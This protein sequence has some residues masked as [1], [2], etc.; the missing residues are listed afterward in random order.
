MFKKGDV[1]IYRDSSDVGIV[2]GPV[3]DLPERLWVNWMSGEDAG[4]RRHCNIEDLSP[5]HIN[6]N[7]NKG[8]EEYSVKELKKFLD[9]MDDNIV[10]SFSDLKIK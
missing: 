4:R 5:H 2:D 10:F 8:P 7:C 9:N 3:E 1:V 6:K